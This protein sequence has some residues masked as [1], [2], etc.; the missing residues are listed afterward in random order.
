MAE[1]IP[2]YSDIVDLDDAEPLEGPD[3]VQYQPSIAEK[4]D[5][6]N[7]LGM[8]DNQP[9]N[10]ID[11]FDRNKDIKE[12]VERI[13]MAVKEQDG[14]LYGCANLTLRENLTPEEY[15]VVGQYLRGQYSDGWGES[16]EQREIKVDG[17]ELYLH[18]YVG[19]GSDFQIQVKA[20]ENEMQE[21]QPKPN[22]SRPKLKLLG[23]DGNIFS[24]LGDASRL[25]RC[26]GMS[27]QANEMAD[28][29]HKSGNYY[30]ALGI[31]SEYVETEL[32]DHH[33]QRRTPR[34]EVP[35]KE[36]TCRCAVPVKAF[37]RFA[38][39]QGAVMSGM[40]LLTAIFSIVQGIVINIMS[41][42]GMAGGTVTE[43]PSKIVNKIEAVGMLES[44]PLWIVT[45]LGSLLITV[46]SFV[47]ILTVY[48]R[49][50]KLYMYTA[51]A[52]I[53]LAT[54]AGEP[55]QSVGKNFIRSYAG[56]CLEGAIIALACIIF[57]V[58]A[59]SPP[60]IGDTSLS[61]VTIVWNYVGEL[62]FNLLV[63]VGAVKA[64]DRIVK[65]IMGL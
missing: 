48:G 26:A 40:E 50:F 21:K 16:L 6:I 62:V 46:L 53:P 57:S 43:L 29:V 5:E 15:R 51:I 63:L 31:I 65:E 33:E 37:I 9:C 52:P 17:G 38:L 49:M 1:F 22:P 2:D 47:M 20:P 12:K 28:R 19:A 54:F 39:A 55:T 34:K 44:I 14:V 64:S 7:R 36:D 11:Y 61:A 35:K 32:S 41:H 3:L 27:E 10:L 59:A 25:L 45:L 58:F 56:V 60:A 4:V 8:P 42:S 23:H 30:E 24:I 13:T 18:F